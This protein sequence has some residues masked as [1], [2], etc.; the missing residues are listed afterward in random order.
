MIPEHQ[1]RAQLD[2]VLASGEFVKAA[3]LSRFLRFV[4]EK[5]LAGEG[6]EIKE[7]LLGIEVFD[8]PPDFDP[9]LDPIVRVEARR[10]RARLD[11]YYATSGRNDALRILFRKGGYEPA[12]EAG[13]PAPEN[14]ASPATTAT[15]A[16]APRRNRRVAIVAALALTGLACVVLVWSTASSP[17]QPLMIVT[18]PSPDA[19]SVEFADALS[20]ALSVELAQN[21]ALH[22]VAWPAFVDYRESR[23][24]SEEL[25]PDR[26]ARDLGT[27][28]VLVISV[29]QS[30]DRRRIIAHLV[31]PPTGRKEWAAEYERGLSDPFAVQREL[32]R[33]IAEEVRV[34]AARLQVR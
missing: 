20:E 1:I 16:S 13:F 2:A 26:V 25:S 29:R 5:T 8:R 14:P 32:A 34:A 31:R 18:L 17:A 7:Y 24:G 21:P 11:E 10:L 15:T 28:A 12:F 6:G 4:V 3:R 22:V 27:G 19:P 30:E 9:R 23:S 33:A